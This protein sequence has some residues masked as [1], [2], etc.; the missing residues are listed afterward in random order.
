MNTAAEKENRKNLKM[1]DSIASLTAQ[2]GGRAYFV[3]GF[4]RD[5]I[6]GWENK[7]VD[8]EIHGVTPQQLKE[9][10]CSLGQPAEIG[11]SFGV[12]GLKGYDL[13]IA[14]PRREEASGRGHRD[15]EIFTDPF[16]GTKKAAERRDF[17]INSLMQDVITGEIIDHFGGAA[18]LQR[19]IIRH[20]HPEKFEKDPLRVLRAAQF[21]ARFQFA[22]AEETLALTRKMDL[23]AL[24]KERVLSELEKALLKAPKPSVFFQTL[25]AMDQLSFWFPEVQQLIGVVQS[26]LHHPEGDVWN[27]TMLVLDE[28]AKLRG[29]AENPLGFLLAALVHDFG[30]TVTTEEIGGKIHALK[31]ETEGL[32]IARKFLRRIT[33]E[34]K[35]I[36]YVLNLTEHHMRPNILAGQRAGIKSTNRMFDRVKDPQAL[37]LLARADHLGR[38][39][40]LPDEENERFLQ[41]RLQIYLE[42][43]AKPFV[44]GADLIAAGLTP[45]PDF[46]ELLTYAHKLRLSGIEKETA[47][48]QTLTYRKEKKKYKK[49]NRD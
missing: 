30:K 12:Y 20:I 46:S 47:L 34:T 28:A 39:G 26:P 42:T 8:M 6:L 5:K 43:M 22:V 18:D 33:Q 11:S 2:K 49:K 10:L 48:K 32:P 38:T 37:L 29:D 4:V 35:L 40:F 23:S 14:M 25:R 21:A 45:G 1:A 31:H 16:L 13:D 36:Q 9:I 27:H 3:G 19:G 44:S 24:A 41:E 15:F 17:T 7:D